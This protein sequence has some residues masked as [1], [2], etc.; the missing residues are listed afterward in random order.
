VS[1]PTSILAF[2]NGSIGNTLV[3]VPALRALRRSFPRAHIAVVVDSTGKELLEHCP[4]VDRLIVYDKHG[5][6][7]TLAGY[8][9]VVREIRSVR[10]S[11]A[12]LFKRFFRNGLLAWLSGAAVR[13]GFVT[14]N[15]APFLNLT[16][17]YEEGTPVVELNLRL[18]ALLGAEPAGHQLEV[19]LDESDV[20]AAITFLAKRLDSPPEYAV[21]HYGGS[22]IAPDFLPIERFISIVN[23]RIPSHFMLLTVGSGSREREWARQICEL[24]SRTLPAVGLPIRTTAALIAGAKSFIGFDSGPA[25][26]AAATATPV[27][28]LFGPG[29]GAH[30]QI[31]KW[32]PPGE[33]V[34]PLVPP[35]SADDAAWRAFLDSVRPTV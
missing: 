32:W 26:I 24:R 21:V 14:D 2:R 13:A 20:E 1:D 15:R 27:L 22:T 19:F 17:P 8:L 18:A 4:Y 25:H 28:I 31:R 7:R 23:R 29:P 11:H 34:Q 9:R 5:R 35:D 3:A 12:I 33:R 6:D 30:Q 16:V 10:P